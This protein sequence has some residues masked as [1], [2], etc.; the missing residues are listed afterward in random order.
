MVRAEAER[1][2][3]V[4][5]VVPLPLPDAAL[6][7]GQ[8]WIIDVGA[9]VVIPAAVGS[10]RACRSG[11]AISP[12][13]QATGPAGQG[14]WPLTPI[15][16]DTVRDALVG[17]FRL[18]RPAIASAPMQVTGMLVTD[19]DLLVGADLRVTGVL[20]AGGSIRT[21]G[22]RLDVT[23]A[24]VAGDSSGGQSRLGAGDRVRYD[25]CAVRGAVLPLTSPGPAAT[26]TTLRLF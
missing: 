6:T 3:L 13:R 24:V 18:T 25:A 10:E 19:T 8:D 12:S 7:G 9:T 17:A 15:D 1:R 14:R 5:L 26:W 23:G 21:A 22:G 4:P 16:P 11:A 20:I 2:V